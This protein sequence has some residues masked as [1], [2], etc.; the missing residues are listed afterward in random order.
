MLFVEVF[1]KG[2]ILLFPPW[3]RDVQT[4]AGGQLAAGRED[5]HMDAAL[6]VAVLNG[7]PSIAIGLHA[8]PSEPLELIERLPDLLIGRPVLGAP[9][10]HGRCVLVFEVERVGQGCN[11][12]GIP[13]QDANVC[14]LFS[15]PIELLG[16]VAGRA[17]SRSGAVLGELNQHGRRRSGELS[18]L[19]RSR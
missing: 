12:V 18:F 11:L 4:L 2:G 7:T 13:A 8:G 17:D 19:A 1:L 3:R 6:I 14:P 16:E 15:F 10:N 5:M 9:G